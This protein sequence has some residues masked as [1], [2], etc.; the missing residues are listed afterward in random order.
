MTDVVVFLE[1]KLEIT[2]L[3]IV[4]RDDTYVGIGAIPSTGRPGLLNHH[5]HLKGV[6]V[7]LPARCNIPR[8]STKEKCGE[9]IALSQQVGIWSKCAALSAYGSE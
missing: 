4:E 2:F 6:G 1:L 7:A 8:T 5:G 9:V 3:L